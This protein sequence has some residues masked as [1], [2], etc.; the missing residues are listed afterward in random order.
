MRNVLK[1]LG[2][3]AAVFFLAAS[4]AFA[5]TFAWS[6]V[7]G[8]DSGSGTFTASPN[9]TPGQELITGITGTFD[10]SAI[11]ALLGIG[12]CCSSPANDNILFFPASPAFLDINGV[13]FGFQAGGSDVN[14]YFCG[15]GCTL[16]AGYSVLTAPTGSAPGGFTLT[17]DN[18]TFNVA[19]T[20]EPSSIALLGSGLA[21]LIFLR[22][23]RT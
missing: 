8:S 5:D 18:G 14:I 13:G 21:G 7:G 2:I 4:P 16:G 3:L 15:S 6:Y 17:S 9:G 11:T 10:A 1:V 20:P 22:K 23:K 19:Q 12:V